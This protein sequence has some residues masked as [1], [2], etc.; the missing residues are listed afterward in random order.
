VGAEFCS[1][2]PVSSCEVRTWE[3]LSVLELVD[4]NERGQPVSSGAPKALQA[5]AAMQ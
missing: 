2:F 3:D 5:F 1:P 4:L